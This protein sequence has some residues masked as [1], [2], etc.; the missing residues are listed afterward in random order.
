MSIETIFDGIGTEIVST[1]IGLILGA[2][3]GGFA[4]YHIGV[5]ITNKQ[6]Q[7]ANNNANQVQ[8]G[9]ITNITNESGENKDE[10]RKDTE[11]RR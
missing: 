2:L 11:G 1:L 10:R 3:G 8:I 7:K 5:K 9:S 6:K 4:G